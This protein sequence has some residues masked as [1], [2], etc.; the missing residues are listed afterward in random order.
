[1]RTNPEQNVPTRILII[2]DEFGVR[3][4]LARFFGERGYSCLPVASAEQ[5]LEAMDK[6]SFDLALSDIKMP[7]MSGLDFLRISRER[8]PRVVVIMMTALNDTDIAISALKTGA[9]DYVLKPF[10]LGEV[11]HSIESAL[12]KRQLL[13]ENEEYQRYLEEKV[14][15]R[16]SELRRAIV[17]IGATYATTLESLCSAL[18]LRD[19]ETEGHSQRVSAY[20]VT[21][22]RQIDLPDDQIIDIERGS[23]LHDVGKIGISDAILRKPGLLTPEEWTEMKKHPALGFNMLRH[24]KFLEGARQIVLEHHERWDGDGYPNGLNDEGICIGARIFALVDT[25]DAINSDRPYRK[26]ASFDVASEEILQN[27]GKQFDPTVVDAF[28]SIS[29]EK[30]NLI[31]KMVEA[32]CLHIRVSTSPDIH[33]RNDDVV[34]VGLRD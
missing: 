11:L 15:E 28:H 9:A 23:L 20:A 30:W 25:L 14:E 33:V 16:T 2:D 32:T 8:Y 26:A 19:N 6:E 1:L 31:K 27:R 10:R 5:A 34:E 29:R 17:E 22:A 7:G 24:I 18:D 13:L 4:I 21:V 3:D 12:E